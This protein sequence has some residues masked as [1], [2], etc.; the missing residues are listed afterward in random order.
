MCRRHRPRYNV[1]I[2]PSKKTLM[3]SSKPVSIA[4]MRIL[5][6]FISVLPTPIGDVS[7]LTWQKVLTPPDALLILL[8][9]VSILSSRSFQTDVGTIGAI[10][11][12]FRSHE[13]LPFRPLLF[14]AFDCKPPASGRFPP[15]GYSSFFS[16]PRQESPLPV[17]HDSPRWSDFSEV[18]SLIS[19]SSHTAGSGKSQKFCRYFSRKAPLMD[20]YNNGRSSL[21]SPH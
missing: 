11:G 19:T 4:V 18:L 16:L 1:Q 8:L 17:D 6:P 7:L 9:F 3:S 5:R 10:V 14:A 2:L 15:G 21:G 20:L 12:P 13:N